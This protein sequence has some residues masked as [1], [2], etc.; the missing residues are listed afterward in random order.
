MEPFHE[1]VANGVLV[2]ELAGPEVD[3]EVDAR[4]A[5]GTEPSPWLEVGVTARNLAHHLPG[6][7]DRDALHDLEVAVV[8]HADRHG[9]SQATLRLVIVGQHRRCEACVRHQDQVVRELSQGRMPPGYVDDVALLATVHPHVVPAAYV[10]GGD[11]VDARE[12]VGER[13]LQGQRHRESPDAEGRQQR[14]DGDP[15]RL[16]DDEDPDH[17]DNQSGDV[18]ENGSEHA[19]AVR[20]QRIALNRGGRQ[21]SGEHGGA[22]EQ[23]HCDGPVHEA[24]GPRGERQHQARRVGAHRRRGDDDDVPG[25]PDHRPPGHRPAPAQPREDH[26][27]EQQAH[28]QSAPEDDAGSGEL[29]HA[30]VTRQSGHHRFHAE[31]FLVAL[32]RPATAA[33]SLR[34]SRKDESP[35]QC[36]A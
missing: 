11:E 12:E 35:G 21:P 34:N 27:R 26:P 33:N 24:G 1:C 22:E 10:L 7:L 8:A 6:D 28:D 25:S 15:E 36:G 5:E 20:P 19:G 14:R 18:Q 4:A 31:S 16:Q 3:G 23:E 32:P 13:V 17:E 29:V 2:G 9:D 30:G